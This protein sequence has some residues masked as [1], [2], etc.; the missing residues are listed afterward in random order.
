MLIVLGC[1]PTFDPHQEVLW[2]FI[3]C[4]VSIKTLYMQPWGQVGIKV[5]LIITQECARNR[6]DTWTSPCM[7]SEIPGRLLSATMQQWL[8]DVAW[9]FCSEPTSRSS[10]RGQTRPLSEELHWE[11][12]FMMIWDQLQRRACMVALLMGHLK[13]NKKARKSY[14]SMS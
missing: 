5:W 10:G 2:V 13:Q 3:P 7:L 6:H 9:P 4:K 11:R 14:D 1:H 12:C 8:S